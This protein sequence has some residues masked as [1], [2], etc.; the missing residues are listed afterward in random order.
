MGDGVKRLYPQEISA[1]QKLRRVASAAA[2]AAV[3]ASTS[4][5]AEAPAASN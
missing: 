4:A 1:R 2:P 5:D 3:A